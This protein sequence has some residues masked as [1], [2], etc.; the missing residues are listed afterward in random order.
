MVE[1]WVAHASFCRVVVSKFCPIVRWWFFCNVCLIL[2]NFIS[3]CRQR[4]CSCSILTAAAWIPICNAKRFCRRVDVA[5]AAA[6]VVGA[7]V[8]IGVVIVVFSVVVVVVSCLYCL[9]C[10]PSVESVLSVLLSC[11]SCS[12]CLSCVSTLSCLFCVSFLSCHVGLVGPACHVS[13]WSVR[14]PVQAAA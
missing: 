6:L 11:L 8:S 3:R 10:Q 2:T 12:T 14:T 9:C 1:R 5:V 13:G 4:R 7:V